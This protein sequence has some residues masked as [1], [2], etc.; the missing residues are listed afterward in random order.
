M[1]AYSVEQRSR[2]LG[3]RAALGARFSE[4]RLMVLRQGMTAVLAGLGAGVCASVLTC[5]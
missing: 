2:E 1:I 4:L 3:L 5:G